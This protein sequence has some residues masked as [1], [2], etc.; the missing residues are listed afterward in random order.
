MHAPAGELDNA[1]HH[2]H[3]GDAQAFSSEPQ[4]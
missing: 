4:R 3:K 1:V 2:G